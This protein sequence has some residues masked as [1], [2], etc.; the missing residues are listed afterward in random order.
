[1]PYVLLLGGARSGK[2]TLANEIAARSSEPVT[3][4]ATAEPRDGEMTD[5]IERHRGERPD[6]W[7]TIEET[8]DLLGAVTSAPGEN[9]IVIDCLTLWVSNLVERA[10]RHEDVVAMADAVAKALAARDAAAV[11]ISN[12]VGLGIVPDNKLARSYR[13]TLGSV[14]TVFAALAERT[15]LLV[16]GRVQEL[17][18]AADFMEGIQWRV[19]RPSSI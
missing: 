16:A 18:A 12:E 10:Q 7:T 9:L 1:M 11:V 6:S 5:R 13:D 2:S 4:I 3:F 15:G 8:V 19:R 17:A 14:N